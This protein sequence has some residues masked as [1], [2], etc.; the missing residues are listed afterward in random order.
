MCCQA[1][2][3]SSLFEKIKGALPFQTLPVFELADLDKDTA[4]LGPNEVS[5][6]L[7]KDTSVSANNPFD[8]AAPGGVSPSG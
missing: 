5:K 6:D 2:K 7:I 1:L 3:A 4:D 8:Q